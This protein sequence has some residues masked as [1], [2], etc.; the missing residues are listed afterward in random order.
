L[1]VV[2]RQRRVSALSASV[3]I[4][5]LVLGSELIL[6]LVRAHED[7]LHLATG[8]ARWIWATREL[9]EPAPLR[10]EAV[11]EFSLSRP[12]GTGHARVFADRAYTLRVNGSLVGS[13]SQKPGDPLDDY[14][15]STR[16]RP[17]RN[18]IAIEASSPT[19]A[20]GI[21][22]WLD[23]GDGGSVV[24]DA[25]WEIQTG[26]EGSKRRRAVV[27]GRPPMYPWGYPALP[28]RN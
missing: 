4:A 10:F 21:L 8:K 6:F 20:G 24:S 16:M 1:T 27:W 2:L 15:L 9:P 3:G 14:D 7:R 28:L 18:E 13:G 25:S 11:K 23:L 22:F 5:A 12:E 26:P 17:G 19:G